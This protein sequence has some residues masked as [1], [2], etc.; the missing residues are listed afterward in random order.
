[1]KFKSITI[2][3]FVMLV[4]CV[5]QTHAQ[6][7]RTFVSTAGI[8]SA[9][10]GSFNSPC[11]SFNVALPN[12]NDGGI[13]T[14]LDSGLYDSFG[15][16]IFI[17]VTLTAA[18]GVHAELP[19]IIVNT[20][21]T[22]TVV[23][24]N[25]YVSKQNSGPSEGIKITG[26]GAVHIENCVVDRF[27]TG[28]SFALNNSAQ[29]FINNTVVRNCVADGITFFT[30]TGIIKASIE[31]SRFENNGFTAG[32]GNGLNVSKRSKVT[33]RQS[34]AN[35]NG[36]AGFTVSDGELNLENCEAS[37]NKDG[38]VASGGESGVGNALVSNTIVTHNSQ[39]GFR[40]I[41]MSVFNSRGNNTVRKNGTNTSGPITVISGT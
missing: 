16:G 28:I 3:A 36:A 19:G 40:Q 37:N 5:S 6:S 8:D 1:M 4:L 34:S 9:T 21:T 26:V 11:R 13:V 15:I 24:R 39:F 33:V 10:C 18:P 17:S 31:N 7:D 23:L 20:T 38:V 25:L 12:T 29:A 30:N 41:G 14:A 2:A 35:G 27:S 22:N 32:V